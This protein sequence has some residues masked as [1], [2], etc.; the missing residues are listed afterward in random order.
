MSH[1]DDHYLDQFLLSDVNVEEQLQGLVVATN[2][3]EFEGQYS[4]IVLTQ[5]DEELKMLED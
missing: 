2:N 5:F 3:E 1:D 4:D